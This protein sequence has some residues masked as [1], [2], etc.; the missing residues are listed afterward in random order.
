MAFEDNNVRNNVF[1]GG[2]ASIINMS[3]IHSPKTIIIFLITIFQ[4]VNHSQRCFL[5]NKKMY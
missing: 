5:Q 4:F 3:I 1:A 2:L